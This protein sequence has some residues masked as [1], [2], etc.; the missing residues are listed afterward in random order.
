MGASLEERAVDRE[1]GDEDEERCHLLIR[2][3]NLFVRRD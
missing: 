2:S 3:L 1:M